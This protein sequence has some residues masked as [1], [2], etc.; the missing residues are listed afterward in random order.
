MCLVACCCVV[1]YNSQGNWLVRVCVQ[2]KHTTNITLHYW[3]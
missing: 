1:N 3:V 2:Y